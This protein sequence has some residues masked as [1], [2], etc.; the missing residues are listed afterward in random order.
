[1]SFKQT[2]LN[3]QLLEALHAQGFEKPTPIQEKA[4][5]VMLKKKDVIGQARTGTGK[6]VAFSAPLVQL[7]HATGVV[8]AIVLT[9]TRELALQV[10]REV[11]KLAEKELS[12]LTIYGGQS[13]D[14]QFRRLEQGVDIVIGTPGR[15]LDH[16]KRKTL[17]LSHIQVFVLD[18]ADRMLDMGFIDDVKEIMSY[19]P[20]TRQTALFSATMPRQIIDLAED[21]MKNP[22][23]IM[24]SKDKQTVDEVEQHVYLLE[25][26]KKPGKVVEIT[27]NL[28]DLTIVFC[29][30]KASCDRLE[31]NLNRSGVQAETIHGNLSQSRRE[32]VLKRFREKKVKV[33]VATDVAARGIDVK[34]ISHVINYHPPKDH[35]D[36]VH[37]VG[38]TARAGEK[39]TAITLVTSMKE[40]KL[41]DE[42]ARLT[43][44]EIKHI[45]KKKKTKKHYHGMASYRF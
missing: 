32:Q 4:I 40:K 33:L 42:I 9:P 25:S 12:V 2:G 43:R 36:Y 19:S 38:R 21:E 20:K 29:N 28:K 17:S 16:L 45:N 18:E 24:V 13:I 7:T 37:R 10:K 6:T 8:Q 44:S 41:I 11:E 3:K 34:D 31:K 26:R 1:M 15:V 35:K 27:K 14:I 30:T 23:K 22:K 5:P 39:G